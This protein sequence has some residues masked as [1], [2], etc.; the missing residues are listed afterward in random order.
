MRLRPIEV[1]AIRANLSAL[2]PNGSIYLYGSRADDT[3]R[4]AKTALATQ[5]RLTPCPKT[6]QSQ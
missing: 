3:R 6:G 4:G 1:A 5:Y 2:D